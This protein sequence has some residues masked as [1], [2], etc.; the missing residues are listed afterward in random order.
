VSE[1]TAQALIKWGW[2][3]A[4]GP[5]IAFLALRELRRFVDAVDRVPSRDWFDRIERK[6]DGID[7]KR[8]EAHF[9]RVHA[10]SGEM[11]TGKNT[12][13]LLKRDVHGLRQD[14]DR[15]SERVR[16]VELE[17]AKVTEA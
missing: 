7:L 6:L 14:V 4:V 11:Q 2:L 1:A 3:A 17:Q 5:V 13:D 12:A 15:L 8:L 9:T 10:L 16:V